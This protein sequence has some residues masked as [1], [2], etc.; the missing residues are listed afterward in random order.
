MIM[1]IASSASSNPS[2]GKRIFSVNE[3][4]IIRKEDY[5]DGLLRL[6]DLSNITF[7]QKT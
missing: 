2:K 6:A 1:C 3:K 7:H 5:S 4:I